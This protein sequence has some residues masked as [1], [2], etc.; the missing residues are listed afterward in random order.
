MCGMY[1]SVEHQGKL[2]LQRHFLW[3]TH[4][5]IPNAKRTFIA[6]GPDI[7]KQAS[8]TE[9]K[10]TVFLTE[11]DLTLATGN[12]SKSI[13]RIQILQKSILMAKSNVIHQ[14]FHIWK[15]PQS[16]GAYFFV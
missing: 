15:K 9:V 8:I 10:V 4:I 16:S 1:V 13:F 14:H 3:K 5:T 12:L 7:K 11:H 2:N 6:K